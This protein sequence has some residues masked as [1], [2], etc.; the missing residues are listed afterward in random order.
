QPRRADAIADAVP[1]SPTQEYSV[2]WADAWAGCTVQSKL[3]DM[4]STPPTAHSTCGHRADGAEWTYMTPR[5]AERVTVTSC[6]SPASRNA[7]P[8][9]LERRCHAVT[10]DGCELVR[11]IVGYDVRSRQPTP[12]CGVALVWTGVPGAKFPRDRGILRARSG[13][14]QPALRLPNLLSRLPRHACPWKGQMTLGS[15]KGL[16]SPVRRPRYLGNS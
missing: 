12:G 11:S 6:F 9:G 5:V 13:P 15:E 16:G 2:R 7:F 3:T 1:L 4:P 8:S 14:A 10:C